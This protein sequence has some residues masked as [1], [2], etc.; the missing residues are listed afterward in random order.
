MLVGFKWEL[1]VSVGIMVALLVVAWFKLHA[2]QIPHSWQWTLFYGAIIAVVCKLIHHVTHHYIDMEPVHIEV[3][4]PAFVMGCIIDTPGARHELE[5]QRQASREHLA[6]QASKVS[7]G[8]VN[9][10]ISV[11]VVQPAPAA[12]QAAPAVNE[13]AT[14]KK[15][16][17]E[18][19]TPG[20][21]QR[22]VATQTVLSVKTNKAKPAPQQPEKSGA[23]QPETPEKSGALQPVVPGQIDP[24]DDLLREA[25][26]MLKEV[27]QAD[28]HN[29]EQ[30][31]KLQTP[32]ASPRTPRKIWSAADV[33]SSA[34]SATT[35]SRYGAKHEH[36]EDPT[37][38]YVNTTI[39]LVFMVLVG[40]SMPPFVGQDDGE[41]GL[42]GLELVMHVA[43]MTVLMIL[44]KMFPVV[45]YKDEACLKERLALCMGMCPRGE[46]GASI[47]VISLE[48]GVS[49]PAVTIA[50]LS[51]VINLVLSGGFV[52]SV[53]MLL[54]PPK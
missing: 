19:A 14:H 47:I 29:F 40:L 13:V 22:E 1:L 10:N 42:D 15:H 8:T 46:V 39:S 31:I 26:E 32:I 45:C 18:V 52:G 30:V 11:V 35:V 37:E 51:L 6:R 33:A 17:K 9:T 2:V 23:L 50:M 21:Q 7:V 36:H 24:L 20:K 43:A 34:S 38:E 44:G 27:D 16:Q 5:L 54:A 48:L 41:E 4:L 28:T 53:K 25:D 49:G 3:L 12:I